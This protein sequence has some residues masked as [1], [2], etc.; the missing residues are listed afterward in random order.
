MNKS[1]KM[2]NTF[3]GMDWML[4]ASIITFSA[5]FI[6]IL[7]A[8]VGCGT[9]LRLVCVGTKGD[10]VFLRKDPWFQHWEKWSFIF[11]CNWE[12]S[13]SIKKQLE[14]YIKCCWNHWVLFWFADWFWPQGFPFKLW[15]QLPVQVSLMWW[16]QLGRYVYGSP[17]END[18]WGQPKLFAFPSS[19]CTTS[20][21]PWNEP[22][23]HS[24]G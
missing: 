18:Y 19:I 24:T 10:W 15:L 6:S 7:Q 22:T 23:N 2:H 3:T 17:L 5:S 20:Q 9:P 14:K 1:L 16:S 13:N 4:L 12:I 11:T 21:H 8:K